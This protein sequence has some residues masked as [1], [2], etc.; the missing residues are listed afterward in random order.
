M[1]TAV[2]RTQRQRLHTVEDLM[3]NWTN[4][5]FREAG[6]AWVARVDGVAIGCSMCPHIANEWHVNPYGAIVTDLLLNELE[7]TKEAS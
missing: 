5:Q 2:Q 6:W 3:K 1:H 4:K 7:N